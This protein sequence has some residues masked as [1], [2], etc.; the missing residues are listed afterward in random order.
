MFG[1]V[2]CRVLPAAHALTECDTTSSIFDVG[3][4]TMY[5]VLKDS[6]KE[7]VDLS[8]TACDDIETYFAVDRKFVARLYDPKARFA[9]INFFI[10]VVCKSVRIGVVAREISLTGTEFRT[11]EGF[12]KTNTTF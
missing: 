9:C 2:L 3:K 5:K 8:Q 4:K 7:F 11:R 10:T 6:Q 1:S 12:L